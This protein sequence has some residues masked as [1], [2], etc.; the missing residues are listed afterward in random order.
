[1]SAIRR[2]LGSVDIGQAPISDAIANQR[3]AGC[4]PNG[5]IRTAPF[6][7]ARRRA[8]DAYWANALKTHLLS[9]V[10]LDKVLLPA[11]S[12]RIWRDRLHHLHPASPAASWD[13]A[14]PNVIDGTLLVE[15]RNDDGVQDCRL[16]WGLR[17]SQTRNARPGV[18]ANSRANRPE[19][20]SG[21][22]DF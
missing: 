8:Y 14:L 6:A 1:M 13:P 10:R 12:R 22:A 20:L 9:A 17:A 15:P 11:I 16:G 7:A 4:C 18:L 5:R 21:L 19:S 3:F 2:G